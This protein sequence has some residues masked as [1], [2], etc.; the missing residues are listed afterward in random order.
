MERRRSLT[1]KVTRYQGEVARKHK[2][3]YWLLILTLLLISVGLVVVYSISPGL[4]ASQHVS[5]SYFVTKQLLDAGLGILAFI[6][7]SYVP[8]SFWDRA[9]K[10]LAIAAI[11]AALV[12]MVTPLD[13]VYQAHRWIRFAGFSFQVAELIKL[14]VLVGVAQFLTR[15]W[16]SGKL[17]NFSSTVKPLLILLGIIGI[18]VAKLQSDLGSTGVMV[19]MIILMAYVAGIP[20]KEVGV[21][22]AAIFI[23]VVLA[24]SSSAYRRERVATFLHPESNC[25]T[26]GYQVCQSLISV[27]S[28]GALGLGL[29]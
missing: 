14:A 3:D 21:I 26:T 16:Q 9:A 12:V 1:G 6:G 15:Q 28:G 8:I 18:V 11:L 27:G 10:P 19:A 13:E 7:A 22:G 5:Q 2:A 29:G 17:S 24:I 20:L 4:A 25:Q 23:L